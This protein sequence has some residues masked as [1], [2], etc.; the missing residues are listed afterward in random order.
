MGASSSK[1]PRKRSWWDDF[2]DFMASGWE[3]FKVK[4]RV[5]EPHGLPLASP[6]QI[7]NANTSRVYDSSSDDEIGSSY[8]LVTAATS[9]GTF[10]NSSSKNHS[11]EL[12]ELPADEHTALHSSQTVAAAQQSGEYDKTPVTVFKVG[13]GFLVAAGLVSTFA[14]ATQFYPLLA[15]AGMLAIIGAGLMLTAQGM[16]NGKESL[17]EQAF[18]P[19]TPGDS[20]LPLAHAF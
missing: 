19:S 10:Q 16:N 2:C 14:V 15:L 9:S 8:S 3:A 12:S 13:F 7:E 17:W 18:P 1:S 11:Q 20:F 5:S 6:Q 4:I